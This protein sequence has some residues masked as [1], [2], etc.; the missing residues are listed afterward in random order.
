MTCQVTGTQCWDSA[1]GLVENLRLGLE[2]AH[3]AQSCVLQGLKAYTRL[4]V[5]WDRPLWRRF[6]VEPRAQPTIFLSFIRTF[7]LDPLSPGDQALADVLRLWA[8][9]CPNPQ[10]H[11]K[12]VALLGW[13]GSVR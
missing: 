3:R 13:S 2:R 9:L 10:G 12:S 7:S 8:R 4:H 6:S 5:G 1:F 11:T